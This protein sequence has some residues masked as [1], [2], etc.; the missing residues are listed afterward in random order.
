MKGR[1]KHFTRTL[2]PEISALFTRYFDDVRPLIHD[3]TP[4]NKDF[5]WLSRAGG[6]LTIS[7]FQ[8][9]LPGLVQDVIGIEMHCHQCRALLA[10]FLL[11]TE[12]C[13]EDGTLALGHRLGSRVTADSYIVAEA[14]Q[15]AAA[16]LNPL[17]NNSSALSKFNRDDVRLAAHAKPDEDQPP[18]SA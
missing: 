9:S 5:V 18:T 10:V 3:I 8:R 11:I 2:T 1:S 15:N 16:A 12:G 6:R 7:A 4:Y 17:K 14:K 13:I